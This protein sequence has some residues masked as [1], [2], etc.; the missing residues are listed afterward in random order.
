LAPEHRVDDL[1]L[2]DA[3]AFVRGGQGLPFGVVEVGVFVAVGGEGEEFEG[4]RA[5]GALRF[6]CADLVAGGGEI[7]AAGAVGGVGAAG[8]Y[9]DVCG[10]VCFGVGGGF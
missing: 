4:L 7:G 2:A 8:V 9:H 6:D 1:R 3:G 5:V 10:S